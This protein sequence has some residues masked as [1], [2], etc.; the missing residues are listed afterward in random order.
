MQGKNAEKDVCNAMDELARVGSLDAVVITRG[1]G[2][3]SDLSCF[4]SRMIAGKISKY[5]IPV[6]SGIGHE[7]NVTITD[8]TAHTF[9][10][11]PTAIAQFI[12]SRVDSALNNLNERL[13]ELLNIAH[14][15]ILRNKQ[16]LKDIAQ[17]LESKTIYFLR[18]H[19]EKII[20]IKQSISMRTGVFLDNKNRVLSDARALIKKVV[21]V[22]LIYEQGRLNN[23][24][25]MVEIS[26][27]KKVMR[28]GF[29]VARDKDGTVI[30][31]VGDVKMD[32][33]MITE[34]VDGIVKSKVSNVKNSK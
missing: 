9:A 3:I 16:G 25:K 20:N 6:L 12:V 32:D 28:R 22:R 2:S 26:D 5:S 27:P 24:N 34:F 19:N 1:G 7:I 15:N 18:E 13:D 17:S 8:M 31:S 11:T 21:N 30:R 33:D 23:L 29:S 4:D 10:K 14:D